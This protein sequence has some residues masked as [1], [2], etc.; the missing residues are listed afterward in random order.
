MAAFRWVSAGE[1]WCSPPLGYQAGRECN[2]Q[3]YFGN[4]DVGGSL[5]NPG[6]KSYKMMFA[7]RCSTDWPC[8][9]EGVRR[10]SV[11]NVRTRRAVLLQW[12]MDT[13]GMQTGRA[14][15]HLRVGC[16]RRGGRYASCNGGRAVR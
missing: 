15:S 10:A 8:T 7:E 14:L 6:A 13:D 3:Q 11:A 9:G 1:G 16:Q 5:H 4:R 12:A 2:R